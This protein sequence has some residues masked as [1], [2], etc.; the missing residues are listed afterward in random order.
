[1]YTVLRQF[2][3]YPNKWKFLYDMRQFARVS[4][5]KEDTLTGRFMLFLDNYRIPANA[6][7]ADLL[8]AVRR[9]PE[10]IKAF[11]A[12]QIVALLRALSDRE[13]SSDK[14]ELVEL[15]DLE[16]CDRVN[17]FSIE[18]TCDLLCA[19]TDVI[20]HRVVEC[21]CFEPALQSLLQQKSALDH[22]QLVHLIFFVGLLKKCDH[23]QNIIRQC[24]KSL[25]KSGIES[26][27]KEE[28][29]IICNATFK[30]STKIKHPALLA[31]VKEFIQDNLDLLKDPAVFVTLIKS[32]R[33]NRYQ[34]EDILNTITCTMFFNKT[35][36]HYSFGALCH[37]LALYADYLYYDE[38][39]LDAL[40]SRGVGLLK[41]C[42]FQS[43]RAHVADQPREKDIKRFLWAL[44]NLNYRLSR[45][46]IE[47]VVLPAIDVRRQAGGF[48]NPGDLVQIALYLWMMHYQARNLILTC[49][50]E[51]SVQA[52]RGP[53][54]PSQDSL[55]LLLTCI[56]YENPELFKELNICLEKPQPYNFSF[57]LNKRPALRQIVDSLKRA[58]LRNNIDRYET[59][60]QVPFI[61][62]IGVVGLQK[63]LYKTVN[64]EVLDGFTCLKNTNNSP[65]G[66]MQLKLRLLEKRDEGLIVMEQ[67]EVAECA[68]SELEHILRDEIALVC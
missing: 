3:K 41:S 44:S 48:G 1:M 23:A 53:K 50:N 64:V 12:P 14:Q 32:I 35:L 59:A 4:P 31:K 58:P 27:T 51:K 13:L 7:H 60:C 38:A 24:V 47:E 9:C 33:H 61:N 6:N 30:T 45:E 10:D 68:A 39:L 52:I 37:I 57:Q 20:G 17:Q 40:V 25:D 49:V 65:T 42:P 29:C 18:Q 54:L 36:G 63:R 5:F 21:R 22:K 8:S 19:F 11:D 55:N 62:I 66:F 26:L 43:K 34:D 16:C 56:Y 67:N 28:L 15:V 46:D 2:T